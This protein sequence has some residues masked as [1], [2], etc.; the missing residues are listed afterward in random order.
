[1]STDPKTLSISIIIPALNEVESLGNH[2]PRLVS[3]HQGL[4]VLVVD[5]GSTDKSVDTAKALGAKVL[6]SAP[7]KSVQMN[8]GA[9]AAQGHILL[10]LHADTALNPGFADQVRKILDRPGVA[11]GAFRLAIDGRGLGLRIIERL[12]NFR[13]R[14]LQLPFGDQGIFLKAD[15][16]S[17]VG[18][19]PALPIMED[20]EL[21]R[22]LKQK[23]RIKILPL[24]ATTS[25][26]RWEKLGILRTTAINQ[27]IIIGYLL[28]VDPQKLADWYRGR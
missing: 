7:G 18:G 11:A 1:M 24:A 21:I 26:R 22:H 28:G 19:F 12:A 27:A 14:F 9:E 23:G 2:L 13:S 15:M 16:F 10:F 25:S 8:A 3:T 6:H 17:A 20:F 4:E 5:G